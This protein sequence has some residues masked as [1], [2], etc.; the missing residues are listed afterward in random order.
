MIRVNQ[1]LTAVAVGV[2]VLCGTDALAQSK[3]SIQSASA[4]GSSSS[5]Y[6]PSN[7][8]DG[9]LSFDARW[10]SDSSPANVIADLGSDQDVVQVGVAWGRGD[11][12]TYVFEI[13]ARPGTS[14]PWTKV[15]DDVSR[16]NTNGVELYDI[17]DITAR[18]IRV[19]TFSNSA[20]PPSTEVVEIEVYGGANP[21]SQEL[22]IDKAFAWGNTASGFPASNVFDENTG[23]RWSS[24]SV[25]AQVI[26]ELASAEPVTDVGV[27]WG[28]GRNRTYI[29]EIW[30]RPGTSGAWT[31][32]F[33]DVSSGTT[34]GVEVYDITGLNARQVRIKTFS[35]SAN[36]AFTDITEVKLF[37]RGGGT[38]GGFGLDPNAPPWEN[39]DLSQW[40]LDTPAPRDNSPCRAER[41]WD[42][43]W[44]GNNP[45]DASSAP[46]F[47]THSDGGMRFV[48]RIDGETTSSS[49]TSG[50][51][52]SELREML[53]NGDRSIDDTGV[54][55]NNWALG[56][57]P[58]GSGWGGRNGTLNATLRVNKVTTSGRSN[59]V[60]R[61]IIGQIHADDDEP[62]RLYYR[63]RV[64]QTKGCIYFAHEIRNGSD[65]DRFMIGNE[66]C[67]SG[68]SNGIELNELF[69]Y[70]ITNRGAE[71]T[72]TVRRGDADGPVIATETINMNSLNSGYDR[73]DEWM[74]FKAGAY[75]QNNSGNGS[76]GDIVT[77]YRLSKTHDPN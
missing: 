61:V 74:Y 40:S 28:Q 54:T 33:D 27:A 38:S 52:R 9:D 60:G 19:K 15:F 17:T 46:F 75:T 29:F 68:P 69:S 63:K 53:R 59:Q 16:G 30:A 10:A 6:P 55:K 2:S 35:N 67:T 25:P 20:G 32:V 1:W 8:I 45:L 3:L 42:Y 77:F 64:G 44:D 34:D 37:R 39:F 48:T 7:V 26:V 22:S 11:S 5:S 21:Q 56:Y 50:F 36:A 43:Q 70:T 31:K 62:L 51:V 66:S 76:D 41:T 65:V 12:R 18:Q 23:T 47:F 73:S 71:I 24:N 4:W 57:Q 13:W 58:S 72:V 49:C 14:G